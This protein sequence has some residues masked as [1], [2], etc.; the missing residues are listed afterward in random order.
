[1]DTRETIASKKVRCVFGG[2]SGEFLSVVIGR[3]SF[4]AA[5]AIA[6]LTATSRTTG[7]AQSAE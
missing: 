3:R 1:V 5:A 2:I 7:A 4:A 6:A